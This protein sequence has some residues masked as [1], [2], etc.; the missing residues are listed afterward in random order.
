MNVESHKE[1]SY[2]LFLLVEFRWKVLEKSI[3]YFEKGM[4]LNIDSFTD[5]PASH[6]WMKTLI[7][8][9]ILGDRRCYDFWKL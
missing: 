7:L 8:L 1:I 9:E 4:S 6:S 5:C 2:K 3:N